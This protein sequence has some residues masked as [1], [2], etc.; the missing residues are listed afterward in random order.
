M[1]HG[2]HQNKGEIYEKHVDDD[3]GKATKIYL[4]ALV[5]A[6]TSRVVAV[7]IERLPELGTTRVAN[8]D[9]MITIL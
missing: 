2:N 1:G 4:C 6:L 7:L 5:S 9:N 8:L 3:S